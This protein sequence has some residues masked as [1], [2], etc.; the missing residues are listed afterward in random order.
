MNRYFELKELDEYLAK[1]SI[2]ILTDGKK[3]YMPFVWETDWHI[4]SDLSASDEYDPEYEEIIKRKKR[5]MEIADYFFSSAMFIDYIEDNKTKT[6]SPKFKQLVELC[7][8][9]LDY[10]LIISTVAYNISKLEDNKNE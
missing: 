8:N 10:E 7:S 1:V 2:P 9:L 5:L 4:L 6:N 3:T